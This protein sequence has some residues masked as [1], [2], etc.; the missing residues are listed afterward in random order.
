D[1]GAERIRQR[2]V[3]RGRLPR[4]QELVEREVAQL[5]RAG[6]DRP[7]AKLDLEIAAQR[8]VADAKRELL[9]LDAG[10]R[11]GAPA[12]ELHRPELAAA[13]P[14]A[15]ARETHQAIEAR[16][17]QAGVHAPAVRRGTAAVEVQLAVHRLDLAVDAGALAL[18][19]HL[20]AHDEAA[21]GLRAG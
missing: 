2:V 15:R 11:P 16:M 5:Q 21:E 3:E 20:G 7:L 9:R 19:L 8:H 1:A 14:V 12:G 10:R 18:A 4:R 6:E 17:L 13:G